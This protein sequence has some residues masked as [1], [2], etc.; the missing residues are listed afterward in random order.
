MPC[1]PRGRVQRGKEKGA[2]TIRFH[3]SSSKVYEQKA[4]KEYGLSKGD[5]VSSGALRRHKEGPSKALR[6]GDLRRDNLRLQQSP[7]WSQV[8]LLPWEVSSLPYLQPSPKSD[9]LQARARCVESERYT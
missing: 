3:G 5:Q 9:E 4:V 6:G 7:T 1:F 2:G 8:R